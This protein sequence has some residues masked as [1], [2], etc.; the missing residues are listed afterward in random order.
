M[1]KSLLILAVSLQFGAGAPAHAEVKLQRDM[2]SAGL[3]AQLDSAW[4]AYRDGELDASR[5]QYQAAA[6]SVPENRDAHLGLAALAM[7]EGRDAEAE[8]HL[9]RVL[10]RNPQD[11]QAQAAL[12]D[13]FH[14]AGPVQESRLD[15]LLDAQSSQ[16][17]L[18][19]AR[20]NLHARQERWGEA[21]R[22]YA[23]AVR[24]AGQVPQYVYN[25]A[26]A[27]EHLGDLAPAV[28]GFRLALELDQAGGAGLD[29]ASLERHIRDL[30][31]LEP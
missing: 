25:L 1:R 3:Q 12:S 6:K 30:A 4:R 8:A 26:V 19:Y 13:L 5:K 31:G 11:A 24:L 18:F 9:R 10:R 20:G 17:I 21:A 22:D 7:R 27:Q 29:H 14:S 23:S 28:A 15:G 16:A 2:P